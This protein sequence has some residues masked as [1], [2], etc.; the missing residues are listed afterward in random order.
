MDLEP[1]HPAWKVE[2]NE[3]GEFVV[4]NPQGDLEVLVETPIEVVP[5]F[6]NM[7]FELHSFVV[8]DLKE[9][10]IFPVILKGS[11]RSE[12][13]RIGL[14]VPANALGSVE[15]SEAQE[16]YFREY[17]YITIKLAL[18]Q[19]G[20]TSPEVFEAFVDQPEPVLFSDLFHDNISFFALSCSKVPEAVDFS[21]DRIVPS[22][23]G[24][25]YVPAR[26]CKPSEVTWTGVPPNSGGKMKVGLT[27]GQIDNPE[28]MA[29]LFTLSATSGPSLVTQY[30]YLYQ[31]FEYLMESVMRH[32]L[33]LVVQTM[34]QD[35]ESG[36]ASAKDQFDLLGD[37]IRE[38]G[39]LGLLVTR[40][41]D[42]ASSLTEFAAASQD[43][44]ESLGVAAK[45]G[46]DAV[47]KVRNFLFHQ[48]R[49][50]PSHEDPLLAKVV[51][52][53]SQYMPA[54]LETYKNPPALEDMPREE[55]PST[56]SRGED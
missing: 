15:H 23:I 17:A 52:A 37:E 54:L 31:V 50:L 13:T 33:P 35:L 49:N 2:F 14:M 7:E 56:V 41:S 21:M 5:S 32:R 44:L 28:M 1:T 22:L 16:R 42:C 48:A 51:E 40:Y 34:I 4:T 24:Y 55:E 39:R 8:R 20:E 53:F 25:G 36:T 27:S 38:K 9:S 46:I 18:K 47:Y 26:S 10:S 43:F 29:K 3:D 6:E 30:F 45:P 12:S 19:L 11:V